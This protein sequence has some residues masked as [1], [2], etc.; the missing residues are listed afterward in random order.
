[1]VDSATSDRASLQ[2]ERVFNAVTL[3][4]A[5]ALFVVL[6]EDG[7]IVRF[8][9]ACERTT[10]YTF[11]EVRG[12]RTQDF[13]L[14][15]DDRQ[16]ALER[17]GRQLRTGERS[18]FEA[19]WVAKDGDMR[20][21]AWSNAVLSKEDGA[22]E[23][24]VGS[25]VDITELAKSQEALRRSE[26]R[27]LRLVET[28]LDGI[29]IVDADSRVRFANDQM[30]AMLGLEREEVEGRSIYD[31]MDD[32]AR[33]RAGE[34]FKRREAGIA[35]SYEL[36]YRRSDG[37][38]FWA[39]V[40]GTP[41]TD[42]DGRYAGALAVIT[43]IT[44]RKI[45]E[46]ERSRTQALLDT[47]VENV[48]TAIF[49]KEA[50][51]LRFVRVNR[52]EEDLLGI[53]RDELLGKSIREL[54]PEFAE[55]IDGGDRETIAGRRL[56]DLPENRILSRTQG[57]RI[58]HTK[59]VPIFDDDGEALYVLGISEDVRA[60]TSAGRRRLRPTSRRSWFTARRWRRSGGWQAE[61][62]TT[63]TTCSPRS[64]ATRSSHGFGSERRRRPRATL[65]RSRGQQAAP[66]SSP[67]SCSRSVG[68]R[69]ER[70]RSSTSTR[71]CRT[72]RGCSA[73]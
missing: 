35:D 73:G 2:R 39:T 63:S 36:R 49:L 58:L 57:E 18:S 52:A 46:E 59:K 32:D 68:G 23:F 50:K 8:N 53:G 65:T 20:L 21:I 17:R 24:V 37:S 15:A 47:I 6:D 44:Q 51:D 34:A 48:P 3:D 40:S 42:D 12:R 38:T 61:S 45:A 10:G 72:W 31:F 26:Q 66:L 29:C 27:Y 28:T 62:H 55:D 1:M 70:W 64:P 56:V 41:V 7:R 25:G 54:F 67:G 30:A 22:P 16:A 19:H 60:P 13:L 71:S 5:G 14:P 11:D 9:K 33:L 4:S 43:D 69:F